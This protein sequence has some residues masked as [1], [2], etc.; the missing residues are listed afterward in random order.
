MAH[1]KVGKIDGILESN[2]AIA[3]HLEVAVEG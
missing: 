3:S 2:G 1:R